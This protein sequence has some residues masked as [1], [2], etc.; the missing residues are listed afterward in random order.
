MSNVM[1][2]AVS[3][4]KKKQDQYVFNVYEM[5]EINEDS[6]QAE[7]KKVKV[8][9]IRRADQRGTRSTV[10]ISRKD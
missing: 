3:A 5:G 10:P 8:L 9:K 6:G 2:G 7:Y 4:K 1:I